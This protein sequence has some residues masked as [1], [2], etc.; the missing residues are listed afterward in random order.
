MRIHIGILFDERQYVAVNVDNLLVRLIE[1]RS[2]LESYLRKKTGNV[3]A[4]D[5]FVDSACRTPSANIIKVSKFVMTL[6]FYSEICFIE[7]CM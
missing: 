1:F 6:Q 4:Y 5:L 2:R 7:I 3:E